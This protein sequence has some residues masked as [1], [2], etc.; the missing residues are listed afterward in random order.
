M[1]KLH[2]LSVSWG[3][4][5]GA[6]SSHTWE[7]LAIGGLEQ[8]TCFYVIFIERGDASFTAIQLGRVT[9]V[10]TNSLTWP[11]RQTPW[12][13]RW[14]VFRLFICL[15]VFVPPP[16]ELLSP[17][18]CLLLLRY[19]FSSLYAYSSLTSPQPLPVLRLILCVRQPSF[20]GDKI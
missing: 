20:T 10:Y 11:W 12:A 1:S 18:S 13:S 9:R 2:T 7:S 8:M 19:S 3:R 5:R 15:F 17:T 4:G 14:S 6:R 16:W